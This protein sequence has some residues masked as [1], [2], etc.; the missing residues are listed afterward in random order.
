MRMNLVLNNDP[1]LS[2][3]TAEKN[4][5]CHFSDLNSARMLLVKRMLGE[6]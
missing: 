3:E 2:F 1:K 5:H 6:T 4:L